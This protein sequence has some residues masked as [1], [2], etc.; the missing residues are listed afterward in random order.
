M[1]VNRSRGEEE[2]ESEGEGAAGGA[3]KPVS[4]LWGIAE[5]AAIGC[6]VTE[7]VVEGGVDREVDMR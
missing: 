6:R 5:R 7:W 1:E 2:G 3:V 4:P